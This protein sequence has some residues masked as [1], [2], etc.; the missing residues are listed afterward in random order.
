MQKVLFTL[1]ICLF[2]AGCDSGVDDRQDETIAYNREGLIKLERVV[3]DLLSENASLREELKR[4]DIKYSWK[5][6]WCE[7]AIRT[8][9]NSEGLEGVIE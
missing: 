3:I 1:L 6:A 2:F 7:D 8:H 5:L 9:D 4:L